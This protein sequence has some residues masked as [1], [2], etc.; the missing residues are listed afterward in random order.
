MLRKKRYSTK[1]KNKTNNK[2]KTK[3]GYVYVLK[4]TLDT[5]EICYKI[6]YSKDVYRRVGEYPFK[7]EVL[8]IFSGTQYEAYR[9]EQIIHKEYWYYK[10]HPSVRFSGYTECYSMCVGVK[11][12]RDKLTLVFESEVK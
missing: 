7:T 9:Y 12:L 3:L 2:S 5:N 8:Y 4:L 11:L 1:R 10:Y 6:G